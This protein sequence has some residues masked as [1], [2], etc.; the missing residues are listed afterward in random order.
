M[1][2]TLA[3]RGPDDEGVWA[4]ADA[5][6]ALG[7]RRLAIRD[8]SAAGHQPMLSPTGRLVLAYNGELYNAEEV[9]ESLLQ[10]GELTFRGHSDTEVLLAALEKWGVEATLVRL[11]GMFA[12]ALWDRERRQLSLARDRMGEKPLY[13]GWAGDSFLFGS[14]LKALR[15]H[16]DFVPE[17][18]RS[19]L[20][21]YMQHSCVPAPYSIYRG[22]R[23]LPPASFVVISADAEREPAVR[24][25]W[26]LAQVAQAGASNRFLGNDAEAVEQ[27][28]ALLRDAVRKRMISDVPLGAFLSGG[29]DSSTV[30]ALMQAASGH[31]VKT[32][33]IGT[34]DEAFNEAKDAAAVARHL[35]TEHTE[36][37]VMPEEARDIIPLLPRLY[38]EPF[39]DS[40]QIP[41][42]LVA[43]LARQ[44]VAVSL[45][46][47]G[48]DE[49]FGGYNRHVWAR[50]LWKRM[51][52]MPR[53][54][55]AGVGRMLAT[56][57]AA[58]WEMMA[59][60]LGSIA[61]H[62]MSGHKVH[63]MAAALHAKDLP[64]VYQRL[65][66]HWQEP[67]VLDAQT[68]PT[69]LD[70]PPEIPDFIEQMMYF[71]SVTY[72]PDDILV[73]L[74]RATMGVSLEGRVPFLDHRLVE[75]AWRLPLAMKVRGTTGKWILR[76]VLHKYVPGELVERP[77]MGFGLP[78]GDWLRG[79]LRDWAEAL[80][81]E[82]RLGDEGYL[83]AKL[84]RDKWQQHLAGK[85][86]W[87]YHLW[88]VLMFQSWHAEC[89]HDPVESTLAARPHS[90]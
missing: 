70:E 64:E 35:L 4:D 30:V 39:A 36:L 1:V 75:F 46:G 85:A 74:D 76:Q 72:L 77:K 81:D 21:L 31:P 84:V 34:H 22:I 58:R 2:R 78:I 40:S 38:D 55:R 69:Q 47:D 48:G 24:T 50:R 13:Y 6:V 54:V 26:S 82:K 27:L 44:H 10:A 41:T 73:K 62:R 7:A 19:A 59:G 57:P 56:V 23:K 11:N 15:G 20:A 88:D 86:S 3:H 14:E 12:F 32:F 5:G 53:G 80:L 17:I 8:L 71:D 45:S 28:D 29:I 51:S 9:R 89:A 52:W 33:T 49:L 66:T 25:Y 42:Y 79:P 63:K 37:Y 61:Q 87:A 68:L 67:V 43:K 90:A 83:D 65:A 16:P 18:E 60:A